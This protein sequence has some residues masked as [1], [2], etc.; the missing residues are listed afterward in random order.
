MDQRIR[1]II[2]AQSLCVLATSFS[3]EPYCSL[4]GYLWDQET[5]DFYIVTRSDSKKYKNISRNPSV[6][7]LLDTRSPGDRKE[8]ASIRAVT[9]QAKAQPLSESSLEREIRR[10]MSEVNPALEILSLDPKAVIVRIRPVSFL[11][12]D[13]V[14]SAHFE[15]VG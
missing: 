5:G 15:Q 13:G 2:Q 14:E 1:E 10:K 12:L 6:S 9:I 4:M 8:G 7:L 11:L 3:E